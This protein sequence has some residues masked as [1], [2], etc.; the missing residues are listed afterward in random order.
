MLTF[1]PSAFEGA[2]LDQVVRHRPLRMRLPR[3]LREPA[4]GRGG[5]LPGL[6]PLPG[7]CLIQMEEFGFSLALKPPEL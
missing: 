1:S 3:F 6:L 4:V 7:G 5:R 2:G